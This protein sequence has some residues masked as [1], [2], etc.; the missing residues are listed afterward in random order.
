M[1]DV[2]VMNGTPCHE[3]WQGVLTSSKERVAAGSSVEMKSGLGGLVVG[4]HGG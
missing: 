2:E 4:L 3:K 1:E